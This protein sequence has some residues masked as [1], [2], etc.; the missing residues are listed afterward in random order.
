MICSTTPPVKKH[1]EV[2]RIRFSRKDRDTNYICERTWP[3]LANASCYADNN[4]PLNEYHVTI[5]MFIGDC[6]VTTW[7]RMDN[8]AWVRQ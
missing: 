7:H 3:D 2:Y 6:V 8:G 5:M 1:D 4:F